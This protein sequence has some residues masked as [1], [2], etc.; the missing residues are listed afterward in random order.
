MSTQI[1][2]KTFKKDCNTG[3]HSTL[4]VIFVTVIANSYIG[5]L[6]ETSSKKTPRKH[7][8]KAIEKMEFLHQHSIMND[9]KELRRLWT[10]QR[11]QEITKLA[12]SVTAYVRLLSVYH[13][14]SQTAI[15]FRMMT[16]SMFLFLSVTFS[17]IP[18]CI[19]CLWESSGVCPGE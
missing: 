9:A 11:M 16:S 10:T 4:I 15:H 14:R 2:C 3:K 18:G 13:L 8:W 12:S 7:R 1:W 5:S 6:R 17:T 19:S